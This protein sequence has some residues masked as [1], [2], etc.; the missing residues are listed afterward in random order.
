[1][2]SGLSHE[3]EKSHCLQGDSF[4]PGVGTGNDQKIK[5]IPQRHGDGNYLFPVKERMAAL[6]YMDAPVLIEDR[7]ACVHG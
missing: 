5:G 2:K 6:T 3:G 4:S 7:T 1:M